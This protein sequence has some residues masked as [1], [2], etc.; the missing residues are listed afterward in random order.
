MTQPKKRDSEATR[1]RILAAAKRAFSTT[2]YSH[3]GI[4]E[5]ASLAGTS[6]TLVLRYFG[7]KI[8]LFEAALRDAMRT[9]EILQPPLTEF[10]TSLADVLRTDPGA[11]DPMLMIAMASG[12][13]E[14]AELAARVFTELTIIP[15]GETLG[16]PD[17]KERALQMSILAIGFVFFMKHLPLTVFGKQETARIC[18][19]FTR[20]VLDV[21][22]PHSPGD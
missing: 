8:G 3:T 22:E 1:A 16:G 17:G 14:A 15:V 11:T 9:A 10:A 6:S 19:W 20:S 4:R 2:G 5:V 18:D 12:E 13:R 7:S 21:I